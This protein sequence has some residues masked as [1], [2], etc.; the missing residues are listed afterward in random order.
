MYVLIDR[1]GS[2]SLQD[3]ENFDSFKLVTELPQAMLMSALETAAGVGSVA[4]ADHAWILE[5]WLRAQGA[6]QGADW[7][8]RFEGMLAYAHKQGWIKSGAV[9][10]HI[11][12]R[13]AA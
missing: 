5:R 7:A 9:R 3:A 6:A 12:W 1:A 8:P 13:A 11:E 4:D 10:A 2:A